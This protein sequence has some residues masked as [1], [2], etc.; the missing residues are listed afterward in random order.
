MPL[1]KHILQEIGERHYAAERRAA[2][3]RFWFWTRVLLMCWFWCLLGM[4]L[5]GW[6]FHT[7]DVYY[8]RLAFSGG[9]L[10]GNAGVLLTIVAAGRK[11]EA[12]GDYGPPA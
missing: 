10:I 4:Y 2:R 9:L 12:R 3:E 7:T 11:A 8:G 1:P 6:A 5:V